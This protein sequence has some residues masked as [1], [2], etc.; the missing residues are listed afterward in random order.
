MNAAEYRR[1]QSI[2]RRACGTQRP[3]LA[4]EDWEEIEQDAAVTAWRTGSVTR[5]WWAAVD[6]AT[7]IQGGR[8]VHKPPTMVPLTY[9]RASTQDVEG[10]VCSRLMADQL[11]SLLSDGDRALLTETVILDRA[12]QD[13]AD[14]MGVNDSTVSRWRA[15][16]LLRLKELVST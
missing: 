10:E 6:S 14:E 4:V 5:T 9:D 3:F 16:A 7:K 2:V 1:V 15:G 11:L 12:Q 8:R 13:V